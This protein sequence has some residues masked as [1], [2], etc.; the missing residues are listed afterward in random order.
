M[1][2]PLR[3]GGKMPKSLQTKILKSYVSAKDFAQ[4]SRKARQTKLSVSTFIKKVCLG[5]Q[6]QSKTDERAVLALIDANA[7]MGRLGGLF[8]KHL[9][10]NA[11]NDEIRQVLHEILIAKS[12]VSKQVNQIAEAL[13]GTEPVPK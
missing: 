3:V 7:Q 10:E 5:N 8:K 1:I 6:I 9:A 2:Q 13:A 12:V 4:I 11:G